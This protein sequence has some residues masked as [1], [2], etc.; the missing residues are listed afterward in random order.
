MLSLSRILRPKLLPISHHFHHARSTTSALLDAEINCLSP[1]NPIFQYSPQYSAKTIT[2]RLSNC[3]NL[4]ELNQLYAHVIKTQMLESYSA[5]FYWN[6]IIRSYT[7]LESP[8][9]ALSVFI[10]M[11]RAGVMPDSY[12]LPI[13]L[14]AV[15]Q[16]FYQNLGRQVHSV[17]I[18]HG[19]EANEYCESGFISLYSKG[20][21]FESAQK[22]FEE[23][24]QRK[25]GS[26][27]AIMAGLSQGGGGKEAINMFMELKRSGFEPDDVT[28]VSVT[29]AC[30]SLG[31]LNLALQ[32]HKCAF[33]A[34]SSEKSDILMFNSLIDM[35]GK[36]GRMDFAY[37]VFSKMGERN[38]SSWTSM[39][40][41]YAMNGHV[42]EALKCFNY[43]KE[44]GMRPNYVTFVGVLSACVH[45]GTVREGEYYFNMMKKDY[46]IEPKLQHYGCMVD[47]FGRAGLLEEARKM[48]EE[49]PMEAN[50]VIWGCLMGACE[51]YGNV[52]M[53]KWVAKHLQELEPWNDGVYVALSNIYANNGLWREVETV[54]RIMKERRLAKVPA[55]SSSLCFSAPD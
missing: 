43:M 50:V 55:Y 28:M 15:C 39:I 3:T 52:K 18:K 16:V 27:N 32:L 4:S 5:P 13:V 34:K 1:T 48:V 12:T 40:V 35:Y 49:M 53:G 46:G 25:L 24:P 30:G 17:A 45:G 8:F 2:H 33:Q 26:W 54:R 20:G 37:K 38:V 7:K 41:G 51:K 21:E 44:A 9:Q 19:L 31:D 22:V 42:N 29:S 47:L 11:Y 36:C 10:E 23:N 14:K 6:T